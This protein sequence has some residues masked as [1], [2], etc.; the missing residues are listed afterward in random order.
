[1]KLL[2]KGGQTLLN[3]WVASVLNPLNQEWES[4][5]SDGHNG[6][7]FVWVL[8][9]GAVVNRYPFA[10]RFALVTGFCGSLQK[11]AKHCH[12]SGQEER[13]E[14]QGFP[15]LHSED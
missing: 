7:R 12:R 2:C 15:Q 8:N 6:D 14:P 9:E 3:P 5:C 10:E 4:V 1:L 11:Y 13:Y